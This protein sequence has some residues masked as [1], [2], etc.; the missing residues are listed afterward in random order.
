MAME[1]FRGCLKFKKQ[2]GGGLYS[3][4][5]IPIVW[6]CGRVERRGPSRHLHQKWPDQDTPS[7]T[8]VTA[9]WGMGSWVLD[10][11][12]PA[13]WLQYLGSLRRFHKWHSFQY[14]CKWAE[15]C[16]LIAGESMMLGYTGVAFKELTVPFS[17]AFSHTSATSARVVYSSKSMKPR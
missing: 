15:E 12:W 6:R 16:P 3:Y 9:V 2:E 4:D 1:V 14:Y 7:S 17:N 11:R 10:V 8:A 5:L 13:T